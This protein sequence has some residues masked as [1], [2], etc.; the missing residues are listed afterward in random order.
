MRP[1]GFIIDVPVYLS[2]AVRGGGLTKKQAIQIASD[3][4]ES[5]QPSQE[6][7]RRL[8]RRGAGRHPQHN[9]RGYFVQI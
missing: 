4:A 2:V 9:H 8:C 7:D 1:A 3:Y 6:R 5:L